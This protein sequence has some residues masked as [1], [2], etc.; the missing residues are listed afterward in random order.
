MTPAAENE[1]DPMTTLALM[2]AFYPSVDVGSLTL[3]QVEGYLS[4]VPDVVRARE[5]RELSMLERKQLDMVE[6]SRLE[7]NA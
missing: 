4:R 1:P 7:N 2:A 3:A 6:Q 5:N